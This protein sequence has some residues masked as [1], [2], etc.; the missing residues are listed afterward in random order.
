[1]PLIVE[2]WPDAKAVFMFFNLPGG[3]RPRFR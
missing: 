1:M 3:P 2:D